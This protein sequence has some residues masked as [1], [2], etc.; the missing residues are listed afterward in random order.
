M[1]CS[2]TNYSNQQTLIR[3]VF[4]LAWFLEVKQQYKQLKSLLH[5]K[6]FPVCGNEITYLFTQ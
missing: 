6:L 1:F 3:Y 2:V 4:L 5:S